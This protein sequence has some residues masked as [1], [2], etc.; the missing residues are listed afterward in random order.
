[1][2]NFHVPAYVTEVLLKL[3]ECGHGAYLVGGCVRD[4]LLGRSIHDWDVTTS[5]G[6]AEVQELFPK[7]VETGARFGTVTVLTGGGSVEVT[8]FRSEGEYTDGRR[9][10][11]VKFISD[12]NEDLKRRDFTINA[13][14][15]KTTGDIIDLFN[16]REDITLQRI[17]CVGNPQSRFSE[18]A[19]RMFRALRFSA[20]LGFD[21]EANTMAAMKKCA[22]M[23]GNLSAERVRDE[24]EKILMSER[25]ELAGTAI[26]I[27]L[28]EG[29]VGRAAGELDELK[30][31]AA[32]PV[33]P[34]LRW[35][36]FS[37]VLKSQCLIDHAEAFL[38]YMRLDAKTLRCGGKGA[39]KAVNG[40]VPDRTGI[41]R[42]LAD[43]GE[44]TV[45]CMAAADETLRGGNAV[46]RVNE[47]LSSG[48]CCSLKD[49]TVTGDDLMAL[50]Y[51]KGMVLGNTLHTLLEHVIEYPGDNKRE[52][53]LKLAENSK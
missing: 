17:R 44:E 31:I 26:R 49:L 2:T 23:A 51:T 40:P 48:E 12:L 42:L 36:A 34:A 15:M 45:L 29:R 52:I 16:G 25:P 14:A 35:S 24:T 13:M 28:F 7:T 46:R 6:S 11:R 10:G 8:T 33:K 9:P 18:D 3:N 50:G 47:V 27:G 21:I 4:M 22:P 30:R 53:L 19:L 41:K 1:M 43:M 38:Q 39:Q 37:A 20:E 5:A 32:L